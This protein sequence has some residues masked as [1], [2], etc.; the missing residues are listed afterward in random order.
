MDLD[1]FVILVNSVE[2]KTAGDLA[3]IT[4]ADQF[5]LTRLLRFLAAIYVIQEDGE[6]KYSAN[7][8]SKNLTIPNLVAGVKHTFDTNGFGFMAL[9]EFLKKTKYQNPANSDDCAFHLGHKTKEPIFKWFETH[10]EHRHNF[11]VW[12]SGQREGRANWLDFFPLEQQ[13]SKGSNAAVDQV[14][15]VDVGGGYGHEIKAIKAKYPALPGRMILQDLP[16]NIAQALDV[17]GMDATS[18][19]FF[20][21][22]PVKGT[23]QYFQSLRSIIIN[24]K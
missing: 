10:P 24:F 3:K 22:Q 20:T 2:S 14:M 5:L 7:N 19:D 4:G 9:P 12:M 18:H 6:G 15:I 17:E 8:I 21:P 1:L 11:N 23:V 13:I 16:Q